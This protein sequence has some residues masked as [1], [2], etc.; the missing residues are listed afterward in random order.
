MD[1]RTFHKKIRVIL[2][3]LHS[4]ISLLTKRKTLLPL[5]VLLF[6]LLTNT[7]VTAQ[8]QQAAGDSLSTD[9]EIFFGQLSGFLLNTQ[10]KT[11][12]ERSQKLLDRFYQSWSVGRF[13][14]NEKTAIRNL[15]EK[16]RRR[17]MRTF[18]DLYNYIYNLTLLAES[19]QPPGSIIDWHAFAS[20][21]L[22]KKKLQ[23]F[24]DFLDFNRKLFEKSAFYDKKS[25]VWYYRQGR[26]RFSFD[27]TFRLNFDHLNLVIASRKDS[28]IFPKTKGFFD[29]NRKIWKGEKGILKWRRF[30]DEYGDKIYAKFDNYTLNVTGSLFEIDSARLYYKRFFNN[31]VL[32][33]LTERV[34]VSPPGKRSSY[35]RFESYRSDF[36]RKDIYPGIDYTGGYQLR[37]LKL[38]GYG[39]NNGKPEIK[40]YYKN[41]PVAVILSDMFKLAEDKINASN[42]KITFYIE[43]DSIFHPGL[44][45]RYS[46]KDNQA[47][48]YN[49]DN[50]SDIV[51]FY[52][53]YH[54]IDMYVPAIY[55]NLSTDSII[56]KRLRG[57]NPVNKAKF[58]SANFFSPENFY[59]MQGIDDINPLYV[60]ANYSYTYST[61]TVSVDN[62]AMFMKKPP[63]QI[64]SLFIRMAKK[65][66]LVYDSKRKK[67]FLKERFFYFLDA[68][69]GRIDYDVLHFN[70]TVT[71]GANASLNLK[72]NIL[73]IYGVSQIYISDS[74][75][76]YI[77][78]Y[79]KRIA[80]RKNRDFSF[81]G[82]V[83]AGLFDFYAHQSTFV[84][85]SFM[86]SLN[87]VDSMAFKIKYND[88]ILNK[89][90][91]IKVKNVLQ[92]LNATIY[93]DKPD[94]KS[95]KKRFAQY[96][97][98]VSHDES[99]VYYNKKSIQDSTLTPDRFYY[100][101][102]PFVFDSLLKFS[103]DGLSF[104]GELYSGGIFPV[105]KEPLKVMP[106]FSL[107]FYH[108]TGDKGYEIYGDK[109][110]FG[111]EITLD[112]NG[113][114][115]KGNLRFLSI[116][117]VS[118]KFVF[119]PDSLYAF[120]W[121][122]SGDENTNPYDF[123]YVDADSVYIHWKVDTNNMRVIP[124]EHPFILY[125]SSNFSGIMDINPGYMK[126]NGIFK[127]DR[128][129]IK[130]KD[131]N[132]KHN[133]LTADSSDFTLVDS[134]GKK[135]EFAAQGYYT[136]IDF[137]KQK[138]WFNHLYDNTYLKFPSNQY[139]ST[140]DEGEWIM[141]KDRLKLYSKADTGNLLYSGNA[142]VRELIKW[143]GAGSQFVSVNPD[144]D[145]LRFY[146]N[147]AWYNIR[148][149]SIDVEGVPFVKVA[150]AV[151]LPY[152]KRI[153]ILPRAKLKTLEKAQLYTDTVMFYHHVYDADID[154]FSRH[155]YMAK[156]Y[157]DY[158]DI[159]GTKQPVFFDNIS[160]NSSGESTGSGT[161]PQE[162]M[163]FLSP[164][165]FYY[166][167]ISFVSRRKLFNFN[168]AFRLNQDCTAGGETNWVKYVGEIDP[169]NVIFNITTTMTD[170]DSIP[171]YFGL[172]YDPLSGDFYPLIPGK[173]NSG[174]DNIFISATGIL[175]YN[176]KTNS[177][178]VG[179]SEAL[180]KNDYTDNFVALNTT[181]CILYGDGFFDMNLKT[182]MVKVTAAGKFKHEIIPHKTVINTYLA[183]NFTFDKIAL[184]TIADSIRHF[185][186]KPA[187]ISKG[188]YPLAIRKM[189]G[190]I[191]GGLALNELTLYGKMKK[192]PVELQSTLTFPE[193]K[194]VWNK[195][196]EAFVSEGKIAVGNIGN[197]TVNKL[198]DGFIEIRPG[199]S[200]SEINILIKDNN[201]KWYFFSY[202]H[203]I[204]QFVSSDTYLNDYVANIGEDKRILN[205][206][207]DE[208][209][210]E[211]VISTKRKMVNFLR[212]IE[213]NR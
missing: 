133:G 109:G 46:V 51:P 200:G 183:L 102:E 203:N 79:D 128:A 160:V 41:K 179:T 213:E 30:G 189:L 52:D 40:M 115:G 32:G 142:G 10:S 110:I 42:A 120:A 3:D 36:V 167:D 157:V 193:I 28:A 58:K 116:N 168:G 186:G 195:N 85:D 82:Q 156:G 166:G 136:S 65:G 123:P 6:T 176:K 11:Y 64:T 4:V 50:S 76:V 53:S 185:S 122:F 47:V 35:P 66:L 8:N 108:K 27:S 48:F 62:F 118:D 29:Y 143:N 204:M 207:S 165:Y 94:N 96:P 57:V 191:K 25:F 163:L 149:A 188:V 158:V 153:T 148:E 117:T 154:I 83:H 114:T 88:T 60:L 19:N 22:D 151:I 121:D 124:A 54:K 56:F 177:F 205:P 39:N 81:N 103:T 21:L 2:P 137:D 14:K 100:K 138:G 43:K 119:Y 159:N 212:K 77:Y 37:G 99:F 198:C 101:V 93:I 111:E 161:I 80:V 180:Y 5:T 192:T 139:I 173:L 140:L 127:F 23:D 107:G 164:N 175:D 162:E 45:F 55:W 75:N 90:K 197:N 199:R 70:S 202:A 210:Y 146:A 20:K 91:Y 18:P 34:M 87:Y 89:S 196:L 144:Q 174:D 68:K 33:K 208:N 152:K 71:N 24:Y 155:Q 184:Q 86:L 78:P 105:I 150:D 69:A 72:T 126:G 59:R 31:P 84:Y 49:D 141:N 181:K 171:V 9:S 190:K 132:F 17:K 15:V 38:Y 130:S 135:V 73:D 131:I 182:P 13:N 61:R 170:T 178:R 169:Q 26:F 172:A 63:E 211:Y 129:S 16:M 125:S 187:D 1:C 201:K 92:N 112:N 113:F 74:Q 104:K 209:Y 44:L 134:S 206:K 95:G 67:A 194:L 7:A 12:K 106:D 147:K 98:L 145:S 97:I